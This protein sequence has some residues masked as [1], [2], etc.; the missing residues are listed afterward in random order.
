MIQSVK[1]IPRFGI[2]EDQYAYGVDA[3]HGYMSQGKIPD[4]WI[5]TTCGYCSVGCGMDVGVKDDR[6]VG[7]SGRPGSPGQSRPFCPKGLCEHVP[8]TS[9][10]RA[11]EPL[12]ED[13]RGHLIP[14]S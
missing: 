3:I 7:G 11:K 9:P 4:H 6:I 10:L 8:M 13:S 14:L 12:A 5:K 1:D 2:K